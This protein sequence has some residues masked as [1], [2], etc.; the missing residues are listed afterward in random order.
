MPAPVRRSTRHGLVLVAAA[1]TVLLAGTVLAALASLAGFAVESGVAVRLAAQPNAQVQVD[2]D[3]SADG[4]AA[5]DRAVRAAVDR[6]YAG[7]PHTTS[8]SLAAVQPL[9]PSGGA[10]TPVGLRFVATEGAA[11][12]A[13]LVQG[14][15][16]Q[17][18]GDA[19]TADFTGLPAVT[20]GRTAPGVPTTV[21][22]V[23]NQAM[24]SAMHLRVG[25]TLAL[26]SSQLVRVNILI[27]GVYQ[28][29][30]S[31]PGFWPAIAGDPT[32]SN[33]LSQS[34]VLVPPAAIVEQGAFNLAVTAHWDSVPA[35]GPRTG[36]SMDA[37]SGLAE[38]MDTFSGSDAALSV[39]HG[40][41]P[42]L[43]RTTVSTDLP[44]VIRNLAG[45]AVVARSALYLPTA[46][47]AVLAVTT[48][49]LTARQLAAH[50][51][52]ELVLQQ[53]RGAGTGRLLG[54]AAAE[55][56]A[57]VL[58]AAV[59]AP[60]LAGALLSGMHRAG[61]VDG[62]VPLSTVGAAPWGAVALTVLVHAAAALLP[63]LRTVS[64]RGIAL[65]ARA[66]SDRAAAAQ[67]IGADLA[68]LAVAVLGYLQL[69]H[70]HSTV[71]VAGTVDP[72]L[73]LVPV[74]AVVAA[75]VL[76][77]RLLPLT[78]RALDRFGRLRRGLVL[79]LAGWQLSRR[80]NRNAG[81]VVLM[82]MAVTVGALATTALACLS[83]L[84]LDQ[85]RFAVGADVSVGTTN[86]LVGYPAGQLHSRYRQLP[87]VTGVNPV[88][89]TSTGFV[90]DSSA[91]SLVG[92]D[93]AALPGQGAAPLPTLRQDLA[94]P[95]YAARIAA[96][97]KGVPHYG[98]LLSGRGDHLDLDV[99]V[100][101]GG[102]RPAGWTPPTLGVLLVDADG[103]P[104]RTSAALTGTD[105]SRHTLALALPAGSRTAFPL[106]LVG[107]SVRP[108]GQQR[109]ASVTL[110]VDRLG[111]G[112][113]WVDSLPAAGSWQDE[114][115]AGAG[116]SAGN[117]G[118]QPPAAPG[119]S[120]SPDPFSPAVCSLSAPSAGGPLL[121]TVISTAAP[122]ELTASTS[123]AVLEV[124]P[125]DPKRIAPIPVLA[126]DAVV[127]GRGL[128][129]G[130]QLTLDLGGE[131]ENPP[132]LK[133][134]V[135]GRIPAIPG[136]DHLQP[137]L[138][139]DNRAVTAVE[140]AIGVDPEPPDSWLLSSTDSTATAAAVA[141]DPR[142]GT[143]R[144]TVQE[145]A[146][147]RADPFR[148]G[149][150]AVLEL[151][152]LLAP[153]FAVIGFTVHVVITTRERRREFALLRAMGIRSRRLAVL[154][155][156]E[157]ISVTLFAVVPGA[158]LG[159]GLA[160]VIM[161]LVTLDDYGDAPFPALRLAVPWGAVLLTA[162]A[163]AVVICLVVMGLSRLLARVDLVRTLRAGEDS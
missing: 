19:A 9:A 135:V 58:P 25:A 35:I 48:M 29:L 114:T 30:P 14:S 71:T 21:P 106:R 12:H 43:Q 34:L 146:L 22:A 47:L 150:R 159:V 32:D 133:A 90:G 84:A 95:D 63:V 115:E 93:A 129:V 87:G 4:M 82:S 26:Q 125:I 139:A 37:L 45:P 140:L 83:G 130:Q 121:R 152:R 55:W 44:T 13:R 131:L 97:A 72:V 143:A 53:T 60:F 1:L 105:G 104:V 108:A 51:T 41:T 18:A 20:P 119:G 92:I 36:V 126:D 138:L 162:L 161:P 61:L 96:L 15:W 74:V 144:T 78:S 81:P 28:A 67:R 33:G 6:A 149:M 155:W 64:G 88:T 160:A 40:A 148:S 7:V 23:V 122:G 31:S 103:Q 76:L 163:T 111:L 69:V 110:T 145:A 89:V 2:A 137:A 132:T 112:G 91:L 94:G 49:A 107:L 147:Q 116:R 142:L 38:R 10:A 79:P 124:D 52:A 59:A 8:L 154:L 68:L 99:Q 66:R 24:A 77:L 5:G 158:L 54:G 156:A 136:Q 57:L 46:L 56:A 134:V 42:A 75:S 120:V 98:L 101:V 123:P 65:R 141:A 153:A 39:Y 113:T 109:A 16:P 102:A 151:C 11:A 85:A 117:C 157:Q 62:A 73:V 27:T 17:G 127:A 118:S 128:A 50:R 3:F 70:Y 80:S 100:Q 86:G